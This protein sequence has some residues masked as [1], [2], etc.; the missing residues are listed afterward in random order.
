MKRD[1]NDVLPKP[2]KIGPIKLHDLRRGEGS[3]VLE[4]A[5][6]SHRENA[7]KRSLIMTN[8]K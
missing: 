1:P 5:Q 7:N 3:H 4:S 6:P 2:R 8:D